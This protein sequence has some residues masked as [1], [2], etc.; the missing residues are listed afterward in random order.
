MLEGF[1]TVLA[2]FFIFC[3]YRQDLIRNRTYYYATFACLIAIIFASAFYHYLSGNDAYGQG[4]FAV[5][6]GVLH[7]GGLVLTMAYVGG[8]SPKAIGK[9]V[10][11]A[12]DEVRRGPDAAKP[13]IVPIGKD[14]PKVKDAYEEEER[15]QKEKPRI[16]IELPKRED[17]GSIPVD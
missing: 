9:E 15:E 17:K 10:L 1:T 2:A 14:K 12:A 6:L 11:Q 5:A 16:V 3:L 13:V 8:V 7:A 4:F